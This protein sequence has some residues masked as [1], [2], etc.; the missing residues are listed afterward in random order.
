[1]KGDVALLAAS[2]LVHYKQLTKHMFMIYLFV[3]IF[4]A[5]HI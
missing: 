5:Q 3:Y 4:N 2:P 1:M